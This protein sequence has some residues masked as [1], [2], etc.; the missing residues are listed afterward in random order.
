MEYENQLQQVGS[1]QSNFNA[2]DI[3]YLNSNTSWDSVDETYNV[4]EID[5]DVEILISDSEILTVN[6]NM[7]I[8]I[9][10]TVE[11]CNLMFIG[12]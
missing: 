4:L 8:L 3:I 2:N 7:V 11:K 10:R 9:W 1:V 12:R 6:T 5:A